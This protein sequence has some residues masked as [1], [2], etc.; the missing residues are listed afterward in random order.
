M[1]HFIIFFRWFIIL[2]AILF[3]SFRFYFYFNDEITKFPR[4][5]YLF[6]WLIKVG[7]VAYLFIFFVIVK[8]AFYIFYIKTGIETRVIFFTSM[9]SHAAYFNW[10]CF[11]SRSEATLL[12]KFETLSKILL[13]VCDFVIQWRE[14]LQT[15][16]LVFLVIDRKQGRIRTLNSMGQVIRH[17]KI[18]K[19]SCLLN[20]ESEWWKF[21]SGS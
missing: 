9:K 5:S 8:N 7:R 17:H 15:S 6:I 20:L 13:V 14:E 21:I 16:V 1:S 18:D 2:S 3:T 19:T 10:G 4:E 11:W 12:S